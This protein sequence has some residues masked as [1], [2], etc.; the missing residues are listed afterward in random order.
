[1]LGNIAD[2]GTIYCRNR[3]PPIERRHS[4]HQVNFCT[5]PSSGCSLSSYPHSPYH[6]YTTIAATAHFA[7]VHFPF[8]DSPPP[9]PIP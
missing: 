5:S 8:D 2:P 4:I 7:V 6:L 3:P 1:M 9:P